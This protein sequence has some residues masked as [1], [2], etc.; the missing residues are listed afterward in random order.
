MRKYCVLLFL[1][2]L[3]FDVNAQKPEKLNAAEILL[4]LK[5]LNF[6]GNALYLAAHPDDE[7]TKLIAYLSNE[8]LANTAYLSLTRGD[9]GQNLIGPEMSEA[10][11]VI[12]TQELLAA[13]RI[14]GG[15]Q[16]FTRANDFGYSKSAKETQEIWNREQV[17]SDVVWVYRNFRPDVIITRFPPDGR[18]GHGHHTTS[19]ILA[20][21]AFELADD[22][23]KFPDQL[24]YTSTW[25]PK[26]LYTNTGRWWNPD[27]TGDEKGVLVVDVG[28]YNPLLGK[29]YPE[30]AA[31]SR[32]QHKSQGFGAT[33]SRGEELEYLEY[34]KGDPAEKMLFEGIDTSWKRVK[35]GEKIGEIIDQA[36]EN[37][38]PASPSDIMPKL[39]A[40]RE[41]IQNLEDE[42]WKNLKLKEVDEVI[43]AVLGLY[44]E[45]VADDYS[46]T[47]GNLVEVEV[48]AINRSD[49]PVRLDQI[50]Y[51]AIKDTVVKVDLP[52]NKRITFNARLK[53]PKEKPYSMPYWLREDRSLGMYKVAN[54]KLIGKPENG[55]AIAVRFMLTIGEKQISYEV[56]IVYKWNDP[57]EGEQYRPFVITPPIFA[58]VTESVY[59]FPDQEPKDV[60]VKLKAGTAGVA[61]NLT[62]ELPEG[63]KMT[64]DR[65]AFSFEATG[66]EATYNFKVEPPKGQ[67]TG[68]VKA[69]AEIDDNFY[70]QSIVTISYDHIPTQI[71]LPEAKARV[72]NVD[73]K[74][75]GELI[76]YIHGAGDAIPAALREIGYQV[77]EL[78]ADQVNPRNLQKFDAVILGIRALNTNDRISYYMDDLLNYVEGGGTLIVQYNTSHRL[79]TK[80]FA[81]YPLELSRD[82]VTDEAA[83]V[84][85]L[86][87]EHPAMTTPNKITAKDF[88]GWVQERGLYFPDQWADNYQ[89]ILSSHDNGE[90]PKKGGLLIAKYGKGHYVYTGYSWFRELPAGVPGAYRIF[91]NL[92]SLG[93][94]GSN[95]TGSLKDKEQ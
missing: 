63:W 93:S 43:K 41:E 46:V 42:F 60:G 47:P 91:V 28:G 68:T 87:P 62:L 14:D 79:K 1:F 6:L 5:K 23:D 92:V 69:V 55:P 86:Q 49:F 19:A 48:E 73:I 71:L 94:E 58:N 16:F 75:K 52:E 57:V 22:K 20:E 17:L 88:E 95:N 31:L 29:S 50:Q 10:L 39:L 80:D 51:N 76:G 26:R 36:I 89:A 64:P 65:Y 72:V 11:G 44:L 90:S 18:G 84:K 61:G 7:N 34:R 53:I 66:E 77:R 56:P 2:I 25:Q 33:G 27:I 37:Y 54:R 81:P 9:G 85:I 15:K 24:K 12:R 21:E 78:S 35:G 82:R 40:A 30:I 45:V 3:V 70:S 8:R 74:K 13:R 4:K 83:E 38:N 67:N 32:S 59:I